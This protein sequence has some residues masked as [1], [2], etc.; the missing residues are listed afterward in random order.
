MQRRNQHAL[1]VDLELVA[2]ELLAPFDGATDSVEVDDLA[3]TAETINIATASAAAND[4]YKAGETMEIELTA[5][6]I[7]ALLEGRWPSSN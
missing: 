2:Q 1:E 6:Q 7:D 4:Q 3:A 5:E